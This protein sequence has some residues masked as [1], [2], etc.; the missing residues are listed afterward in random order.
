M[1]KPALASRRIVDLQSWLPLNLGNALYNHLGDPVTGVYFLYGIRQ[2]DQYY[3]YFSPV[4]R[5][6]RAGAV[7]AGNALL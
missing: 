2:I 3:F 7:K 6:N 1:P 4:I 5:I